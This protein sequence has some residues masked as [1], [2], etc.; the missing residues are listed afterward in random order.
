MVKHGSG[1]GLGVGGVQLS[2]TI[3]WDLEIVVS[4]LWGSVFSSV[5][6]DVTLPTSQMGCGV[7]VQKKKKKGPG[8]GPDSD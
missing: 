4:S 8:F 2:V 1:S 5:K 3:T 7:Y 6:G